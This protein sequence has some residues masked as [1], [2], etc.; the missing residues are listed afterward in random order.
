[1]KTDVSQ[2]LKTVHYPQTGVSIQALVYLLDD[3]TE[4][5]ESL[6]KNMYFFQTSKQKVKENAAGKKD[7]VNGNCRDFF[8][9]G[10]CFNGCSMLH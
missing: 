8:S 5:S 9:F 3:Y 1:M 10:F 2:T 4:E 7:I 6:K